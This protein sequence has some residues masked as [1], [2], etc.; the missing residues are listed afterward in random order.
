MLK[1]SLGTSAGGRGVNIEEAFRARVAERN[2][3]R[4]TGASFGHKQNIARLRAAGYVDTEW[5][6]ALIDYRNDNEV[7][8]RSTMTHRE[9][10]RRNE[11]L[12]GT[13]IAWAKVGSRR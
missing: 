3:K 12:A 7:I 4:P 9:A 5:P 11:T 13:G 10:Y 2:F 6:F 8:K 1:G